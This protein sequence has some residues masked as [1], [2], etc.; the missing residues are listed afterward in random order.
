M[1]QEAKQCIS[2][3]AG[4]CKQGARSCGAFWHLKEVGSN[5]C[6]SKPHWTIKEIRHAK[7]CWVIFS[8]GFSTEQTYL[9]YVADRRGFDRTKPHEKSRRHMRWDIKV[10]EGP[11]VGC[12]HLKVMR[13]F[14][15]ETLEKLFTNVWLYGYINTIQ[16]LFDIV[17][18]SSMRMH[19]IL[20]DMYIRVCILT[21]IYIYVDS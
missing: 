18:A 13:L 1:G 7:E 15:V 19:I 17:F 6:V 12:N 2:L 10:P 4:A 14:L 20:E 8:R 9:L 3:H 11:L 5:S 16:F 21:Y